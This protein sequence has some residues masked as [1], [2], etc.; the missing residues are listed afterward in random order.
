MKLSKF[1]CSGLTF[2]ALALF[3][4]AASA[5][6]KVGI[7]LSSTGPAAAIGIT[8]KNAMLMW[9]KTIAGQ[10]AEYIILDHLECPHFLAFLRF[11]NRSRADQR[12]HRRL[13]FRH[14]V[15]RRERGRAQHPQAD[16][17]R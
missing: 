9:P 12:D 5:E 17:R 7:D 3:S 8:S 13:I 6:L 14:W 10:P 16:N 11:H 2:G 1:M 4:A 15:Q